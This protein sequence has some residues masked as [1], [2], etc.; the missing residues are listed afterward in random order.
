MFD[1]QGSYHALTSAHCWTGC[2]KD[3]GCDK[4][5]YKEWKIPWCGGSVGCCFQFVTTGVCGNRT[6][7]WQKR[8]RS[9]VKLI[10]DCGKLLVLT[11]VKSSFF[12][13]VVAF[14]FCA[15]Y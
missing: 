3:E 4:T 5:D 6:E 9:N 12:F 1:A 15:L 11:G 7:R 14:F 8:K 10:K 2:V 13:V